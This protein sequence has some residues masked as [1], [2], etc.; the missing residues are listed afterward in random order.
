MIPV[1]IWAIAALTIAAILIRP[2]GWPEAAWACIGAA[3]LVVFRL[4]SAGKAFLAVRKG[5]DVYFFLAGMMLV[6]EMARREGL[7]DWLASHAVLAAKGSRARLFSLIY[8]VGAA[9]TALLSNDA[10]A[11]VL[12]PA[13][14]AAVKKTRGAAIPYLFICAFIANAAS[15]VLPISNPA[16]LVIFG[17]NMPPLANWLHFFALPSSLAITATYLGLRLAFRRELSGNLESSIECPALPFSGRIVAVGILVT[18]AVLLAASALNLDLGVPTFVAAVIV[19]GVILFSDRHAFSP[20]VK[21]ISWGV[22][23]LVAGLFVIVGGLDETGAVRHMRSALERLESWAPLAGGLTASF[24]AAVASNIAN[25]LPVALLTGN[26]LQARQVIP[27]IR[28]ALVIG[29]DLGSNF[30]ISGSLATIL[31]LIALR[32]EGENVSAWQ[33]LKLGLLITPPALFLATCALLVGR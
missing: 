10:T 8:L 16:N 33:F 5:T 9:V 21:Q 20:I 24:G 25:N 27:A 29:V 17:R 15:F 19:L 3:A 4:V 7:F 30:S 23:P 18:A 12:T 26:T 13:V 22:L 32:R 11:V 2:R 31:W 6:A 28:N 1:A 14:Y